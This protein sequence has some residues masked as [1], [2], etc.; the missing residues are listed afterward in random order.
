MHMRARGISK[1]EGYKGSGV[2]CTSEIHEGVNN[3]ENKVVNPQSTLCKTTYI[4]VQCVVESM[5]R[6]GAHTTNAKYAFIC[7][8]SMERPSS[9]VQCMWRDVV[10]V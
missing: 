10:F 8:V 5:A 9:Q 7:N 2:I 6:V 1:V 3:R 4:E